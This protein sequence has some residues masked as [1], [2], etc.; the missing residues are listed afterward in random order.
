MLFSRRSARTSE[1]DLPRE[2]S[3]MHGGLSR[4]VGAA[5]H[6]HVLAGDILSFGKRGPVVHASAGQLL[7]TGRLQPAIVDARGDD[8]AVRTQQ[9]AIRQA[10]QTRCARRFETAR[11]APGH[12][13]G[14]EAAQPVSWRGAPALSR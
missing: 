2:A 8:D 5:D 12:N 9:A 13:F 4:G 3:K 1:R 10:N 6:V 14:A 11:L 7:D